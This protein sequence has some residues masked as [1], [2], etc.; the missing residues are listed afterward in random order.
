MKLGQ[1]FRI[2]N[3][4]ANVDTAKKFTQHVVPEVV[5]PARIIWNQAIGG[6][7]LLFAVSFLW[8][9]IHNR[10]NPPGM[11]FGIFLGAVMAFF[12]VTSF[13]K[14]RRISRR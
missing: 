11:I 8:Y 7:F 9:A 6:L 13:V 2:A 4:Y 14:A 10:Q 12:C 5:K 3:R 1:A